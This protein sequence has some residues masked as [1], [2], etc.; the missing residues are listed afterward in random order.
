MEVL[1][2]FKGIDFKVIKLSNQITGTGRIGGFRVKTADNIR[3]IATCQKYFF[4]PAIF[5]KLK[6]TP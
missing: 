2:W 5:G 4:I 3:N 1:C 6:Q